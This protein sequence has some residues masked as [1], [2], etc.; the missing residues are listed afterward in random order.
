MILINNENKNKFSQIRLVE[1]NGEPSNLI[2]TS[3]RGLFMANNH[4]LDLIVIN[5]KQEPFIAK[6]SDY[7]KMKFDKAKQQKEQ[8]KNQ[9]VVSIKEIQLRAVTGI[10]DIQIKAKKANEMLEQ[11][12]KIKIV[13]RLK[14][15]EQ[16]TPELGKKVIDQFL[17]N[18]NQ[19]EIDSKLQS[20]GR[21]MI[22][23][24]KK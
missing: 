18:L 21:D 19:Y 12:H 14:G 4:D 20:S 3:E 8:K 16:Q 9:Q 11:G 5:D 10:N 22:M 15:R 7:G 24:I 6:I 2:T 23:I 1:I 13:V 17:E